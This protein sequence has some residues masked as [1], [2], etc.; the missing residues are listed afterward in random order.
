MNITQ[1]GA[2][3]VLF[4]RIMA[5]GR[6]TKIDENSFIYSH[7]I[8]E[9]AVVGGTTKLPTWVDLTPQPIPQMN[10]VD[11]ATGATV[12]FFGPTNN[13]RHG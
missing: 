12:G 11:M 3:R 4:D 10:G 5:S 8:A 2:K 7:F 13:Y 6:V 9:S 1:T